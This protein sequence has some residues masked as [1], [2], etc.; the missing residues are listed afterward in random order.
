MDLETRRVTAGVNAQPSP[1]HDLF[2]GTA[3]F[4]NSATSSFP[5]F[6]AA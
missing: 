3:G 1:A 5:A 6:T 4:Q 2:G